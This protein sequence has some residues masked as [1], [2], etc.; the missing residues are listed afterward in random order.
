MGAQQSQP[1]EFEELYNALPDDVHDQIEA[2][3]ARDSTLLLKPHPAAPPPFPPLLV[4]VT[5]R[6]SHT[7]ASAA[8]SV[9]PRLQ[10]K[11]YEVIPKQ[12]SELEFFLSFFSHLTAIVQAN[13]PGAMT[14]K[15]P[16]DDEEGTGSWRGK[17]DES[18]SGNN[19][20]EA[21]LTLPDSKRSAVIALA[22]LESDVLLQPSAAAPPAFPSLPLGME[23]FIDENAATAA[24][25]AI[26]GLQYK[27]YKMVP[28]KLSEKEFWVHF[29][30]HMTAI[31]AA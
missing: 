14:P 22:E 15:P 13:C 1:S 10:R 17:S 29:F 16:G 8:L 24:L 5:V 23:C 9:V 4:G 25:S 7:T 18:G 20:D 6:L 30:S 19:F 26:P 28:K 12:L 21:W 3:A 11:H 27:H 2:L 31:V